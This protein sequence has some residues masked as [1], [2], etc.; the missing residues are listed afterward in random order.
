ML[1]ARRGFQR[2]RKLEGDR[3]G[4]VAKL[5]SRRY[6]DVELREVNIK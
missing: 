1:L 3:Y 4:K 2:S 6:L 5:S